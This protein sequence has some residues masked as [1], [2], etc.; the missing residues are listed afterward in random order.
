[1]KKTFL[2]LAAALM[3]TV[4]FGQSVN[5]D[6]PSMKNMIKLGINGGVAVPSNNLS[7]AVGVDITY[8]N[9]VTPGFGLGLTTGYTQYFGKDNTIN[10]VKI[11]NNGVGVVPIAAVLRVYPKAYGF[12][13]GADLG[14]GFLVG[15][16]KVANYATSPKR[17]DGGF[18]IKPEIGY[19]NKDWNFSIH[20]KT[21]LT[22]DKSNIAG[23]KYAVGS[24]GAGIAYNIP[25]GAK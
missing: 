2:A 5:T 19:H 1:M 15:D 23:Q 17:P 3:T 18:Y 22:D 7:G 21:V 13:A 24:I 6:N 25:L 11:E 9:L 16:E 4:A 14:Y 20:Y 8:Q 10:G 12:F